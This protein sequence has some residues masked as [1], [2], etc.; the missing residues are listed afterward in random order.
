MGL[1]DIVHEL[2]MNCHDI[3]REP[4]PRRVQQPGAAC[5]CC[6]CPPAN[7]VSPLLCPLSALWP[8]SRAANQIARVAGLPGESRGK[9]NRS[10][11]C[12]HC[13]RRSRANR[14]GHCGAPWAQ[15]A[16]TRRR[17]QQQQQQQQQPERHQR[18]GLGRLQRGQ[19]PR[20]P[21]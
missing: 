5:C 14:Q 20:P 12:V 11:V 17:R 7:T 18:R 19:Q 13:Q 6:A 4:G 3:V 2:S 1:F 8:G 15:A 10:G 9:S 16:P 21:V